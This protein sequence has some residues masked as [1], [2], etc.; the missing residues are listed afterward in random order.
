MKRK[1]LTGLLITIFFALTISLNIVHALPNQFWVGSAVSGAWQG[2]VKIPEA[3]LE[4]QIDVRPKVL[5]LRSNGVYSVFVTFPEGYDYGKEV[6]DIGGETVI[7]EFNTQ[8]L[9]VKGFESGDEVILVVQGTLIDGTPFLGAKN[10]NLNVHYF[11]VY[12]TKLTN[13]PDP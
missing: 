2:D 6:I 5:N 1:N 13:D 10:G 8:D 4:V 3:D 7:L 11:P 9:D 12:T